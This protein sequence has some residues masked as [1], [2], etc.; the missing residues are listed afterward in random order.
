MPDRSLH[1]QSA[2]YMEHD[3]QWPL[4]LGIIWA[5]L[6]HALLWPVIVRGFTFTSSATEE[7]LAEVIKEPKEVDDRIHVGSKDMTVPQVAWISYED[8]EKLIAPKSTTEQP[9]VQTEVTPV[10]DAPL[11]IDATD[12]AIQSP[13]EA[14]HEIEMVDSNQQQKPQPDVAEQE[15]TLPV[16]A[17]DKI[18]VAMTKPSQKPTKGQSSNQPIKQ[19][20][21]AA[22]TQIGAVQSNAR[23]TSSPRAE[24]ESP[25]VSL[26]ARNLKVRPGAV[27]TY[28]D[29]KVKTK[30]PRFGIEAVVTTLRTVGNPT[31]VVEF[32]RKGDVLAVKMKIKTGAA[33]IDGP[34]LSSLYS[35]KASGPGL[36][37]HKSVI[38]EVNILLR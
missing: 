11:L 24:S 20:G 18:Q 6:L 36:K 14:I 37:K 28:G 21:N 8:F 27:L 9:A 15:Y 26:I 23:P 13:D 4:I 3:S 1:L 22:K 33:N 19:E 30:V 25:A 32:D 17:D 12:P 7:K 35:W 29:V 38:L 31:A 2:Q 10:P 16:N 34:I 5:L